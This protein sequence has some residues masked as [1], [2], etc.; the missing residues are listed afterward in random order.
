MTE[1]D[2]ETMFRESYTQLYYFAFDL[3]GD[4]EASRDI[5]SEAFTVVW[6]RMAT[7]KADN[8][9]GYLFISIRNRSL[10][11]VR[12]RRGREQY[13]KYCQA[14]LSE[15]DGDYWLTMEER[16]CDMN[17]VIDTMPERTRYV[18]EQCYLHQH[19]YREVAEQLGISVN[20]VKKHIVKAFALLR[21]HFHVDR[22][23]SHTAR[24]NIANKVP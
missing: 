7:L 15:E 17:G 12:G 2:F 4:E 1:R 5:V 11:Y 6:E 22:E 3:T 24:K 13:A 19:T 8:L 21:E 16:I 18:L 23:K 10:D 14:A 9:K 20:G